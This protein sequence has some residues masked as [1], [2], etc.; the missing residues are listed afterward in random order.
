MLASKLARREDNAWARFDISVCLR[1]LNCLVG[2][3]KCTAVSYM[4]ARDAVS[5][6]DV[7]DRG[8][9]VGRE[10]ARSSMQQQ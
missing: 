4:I 3:F 6:S 2:L 8:R 10:M 5:T 9:R 1:E 7:L